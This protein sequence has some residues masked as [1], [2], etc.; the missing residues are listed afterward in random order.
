MTGTL[1]Q[2]RQIISLLR[3][4]SRK[5]LTELSRKTG[6]PVST[7]FTKLNK[8]HGTYISKFTCLLNHDKLGY[9]IMVKVLLRVNKTDKQKVCNFL[10]NT[11]NIN[12]IYKLTNGYDYFVQGYFKGLL[13]LERFIEELET[14]H[15][16]LKTQVFY[17]V[18]KVKEEGFLTDY[19]ALS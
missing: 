16:I 7:L 6:V 5:R 14:R 2:D 13:Q 11:P 19:Y 15:K 18:D 10:K 4:D 17:V 12:S 9:S 3:Q 8:Y 1:N